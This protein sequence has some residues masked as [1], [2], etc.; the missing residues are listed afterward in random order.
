MGAHS[1]DQNS[2]DSSRLPINVLDIVLVE[3]SWIWEPTRSKDK[4]QK[5]S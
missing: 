2:K 3:R 1:D 5:Y 4:K